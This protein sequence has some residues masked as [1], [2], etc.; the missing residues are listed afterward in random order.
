MFLHGS[1]NTESQ[2]KLFWLASPRPAFRGW[3]VL[4]GIG[5][6]S[7]LQ[8]TG[9]S[10]AQPVVSARCLVERGPGAEGRGGGPGAVLPSL[11][12]S[13]RGP[14]FSMKGADG[15]EINMARTVQLMDPLGV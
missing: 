11:R 12:S 14:P 2:K 8:N 15:I 1:T 13:A 5:P 7:P 10:I 6:A 4:S 9:W 3:I